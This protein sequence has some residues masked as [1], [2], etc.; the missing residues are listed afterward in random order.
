MRKNYFEIL[1]ETRVNPIVE[2]NKL[3]GLFKEKLWEINYSQSIYELI[4][5]NFK[6][7]KNRGHI[8]SLDE[9]LET[10]LAVP[11]TE[12][13]RLFCF[14]EMYLDL[15]SILPYRKSVNLMRQ[16]RYLEEQ[17]ERTVNLLGHKVV[18]ID[19]K[20]IIVE[21]N[22]FANEAA[23]A[24]TE[25]A[26][27]KEALSV[28]EYNHFSNKGNIERKKEILKKIA[29]L[30][31]PWRKPLNKSSELKDLLKANNDKIQALEKLFYMYNKLNIRH[32]NEDQMLTELS[33]QEIESWYDKVYTLSLFIILG[34]DVGSILYDFEVSFGDNK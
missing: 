31:E 11:M 27:I 3:H 2:L 17:I 1:K 6:V 5:K 9:L 19:N 14:S 8:L 33:D 4:S 16:V 7:Y 20:R 28:L 23:Q 29:D 24:V 18:L 30:L 15:L 25:F 13:E 22:V 10:M 26:D 32:N 34:K 21:N 12:E